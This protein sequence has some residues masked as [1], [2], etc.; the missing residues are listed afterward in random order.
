MEEKEKSVGGLWVNEREG[1]GKWLSIQI[2]LDGEKYKL[3]AFKNSYKQ[4]NEKQPDYR[5]F[6]SRPKREEAS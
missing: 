1:K 4:D 3:V 5:V 2:E 6:I